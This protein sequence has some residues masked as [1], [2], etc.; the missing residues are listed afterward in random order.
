MSSYTRTYKSNS[1]FITIVRMHHNGTKWFHYG[2]NDAK[3][4]LFP[5]GRTW[6]NFGPYKEGAVYAVLNKFIDCHNE[7]KNNYEILSV[8]PVPNDGARI[9][10]ELLC[11]AD[12]RRDARMKAIEDPIFRLR[13]SELGLTIDPKYDIQ[14]RIKE[15]SSIGTSIWKKPKLDHELNCLIKFHTEVTQCKSQN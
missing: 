6:E 14:E 5:C 2:I 7:D 13:C 11:E 15:L 3:R 10:R 9:S 12:S 8:V 4:T 1:V